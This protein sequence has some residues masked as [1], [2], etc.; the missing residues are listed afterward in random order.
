MRVQR[1]VMGVLPERLVGGSGNSKAEML[2]ILDALKGL[3]LRPE[4]PEIT[5][6]T[7]VVC[8]ARDRVNLGAARQVA[9]ALEDARLEIVAGAGH[10]WHV[11]HPD[12]F[13][14]VLSRHLGLNRS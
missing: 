8:G 7:T 6:S 13:A 10:R 14:S 2:H 1:A 11:T 9:D 12:D 4:L 3:D 5:A